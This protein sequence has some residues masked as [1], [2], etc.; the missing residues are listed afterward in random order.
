ML[1]MVVVCSANACLHTTA[2]DGLEWLLWSHLSLSVS[3][4]TRVTSKDW[5]CIF[6]AA[7]HGKKWI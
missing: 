2:R 3:E 5:M 4:E 6:K 7:M 1:V